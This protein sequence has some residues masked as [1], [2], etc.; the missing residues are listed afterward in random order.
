M[1]LDGDFS[2][3]EETANFVSHLVGASVALAGIVVLIVFSALRGSGI[4][5]VSA[6]V[7]SACM[8]AL[9]LSSTLYHGLRQKRAKRVFFI[10]DQASIYLMI[11]GSYTPIALVALGGALGW[12]MFGIEWG[13]AII[14]IVITA[15]FHHDHTKGVHPLKVASYLVMGWLAL[16]ALKPLAAELSFWGMALLVAGGAFYTLG[17]V[18][19]ALKRIRYNHLVWHLFVIFGTLCHYAMVF[20]FILPW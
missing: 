18:F 20:L 11:A 10:F 1:T 17:V 16:I 14:G 12:T 2:R 6:S 5:V 15:V 3:G 13:L 19:F 4:H 7:F 8:L 9:Y